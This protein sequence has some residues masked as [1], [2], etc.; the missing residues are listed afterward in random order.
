MTTTGATGR[1]SARVHTGVDLRKAA[2]D[3]ARLVQFPTVSARPAPVKEILACALWLVRQLTAIGLENAAIIPTAGHPAVYADWRHAAGR[4]TMLIYGHYDVVPADPLTDWHR[5]PF[6]AQISGGYIHGRG[7]SDDKGQLWAHVAAVEAYLRSVGRLPVNVMFLL[8]GE[9]EIGSPHLAA[10]LDA[11]PQT[12]TAHVVIVSDTRMLAID[13]PAITY[14]VRGVLAVELE[15]RGPAVDLHA[16]TFGG[17]VHNP[18][19]A[20]CDLIA[21][22][23]DPHGRVSIPGFYDRVLPLSS[24]ERAYLAGS[25]P[26]D[27]KILSETGAAQAW[28]EPGWSLYERTT[29]RP[30]LTLNGVTGGYQRAGAK[31][32]IPARGTAKIS[33]R[34]V[35]DQDPA[36]V[37][38]LLRSYVGATAPSTVEWAVHTVARVP[39]AVIDTAHPVFTAAA[40]SYATGFGAQ[41]TFVR[42]GGTL[43]IA[44][45]RDG[46]R[47]P[48]VC[49]GFALPDDRAHAP[50][51]RF[52]LGCLERGIATSIALLDLIGTVPW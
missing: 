43:P 29:A 6:A 17:A 21:G 39:P 26:S 40:T 45:L 16:G 48:V 35:P 49:M 30:A 14:G 9:E 47:A 15:M 44:Q 11:R 18:L 46:V 41:P 22:M 27:A 24:G 10:V 23:H 7:A 42:T 52:H 36:D 28:G 4:P 34:L 13:R 25:G 8:D 1:E 5:P 31:A 2:I 12:G 32:V 33:F 51:E 3:L 37:E 20:I 38:G 50:N 19:Q